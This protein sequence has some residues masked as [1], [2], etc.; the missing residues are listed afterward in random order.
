MKHAKALAR[1][2]IQWQT[3][4]LRW[5]MSRRVHLA[6][7]LKPADFWVGI[8]PAIKG[9]VLHVWVIVLPCLPLHFEVMS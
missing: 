9:D 7:E 1:F 8:F 3:V 6:L 5:Q 4:L 2:L